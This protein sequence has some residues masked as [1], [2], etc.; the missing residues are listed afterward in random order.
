ML[1][2]MRYSPQKWCQPKC[3]NIPVKDGASTNNGELL[4]YCDETMGWHRED[5]SLEGKVVV[6]TGQI[7]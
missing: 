6:E 3:T 5:K 2:G 7:K 4:M 1:E